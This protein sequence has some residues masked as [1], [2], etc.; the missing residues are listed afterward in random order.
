MWAR[1]LSAGQRLHW[2]AGRESN[3]HSR[4]R[5]VYSQRSSPPAQPTHW[6]A[7]GRDCG[8]VVNP[9]PNM[10]TWSRRR[11]SNP[12]PAV[13]KTAALPIELRRRG[14]GSDR[15]WT[16]RRREMI[17]AKPRTG[18]ASREATSDARGWSGEHVAAP[19]QAGSGPPGRSSSGSGAFD[20]G[21]AGTS[22]LFGVFVGA[23]RR[24]FVGVEASGTAFVAARDRG[25]LDVSAASTGF[26]ATV[27]RAPFAAVRLAG[28]A[29]ADAPPDVTVSS[30]ALAFA[31]PRRGAG[32]AVA[33]ASGASFTPTSCGVS[34]VALGS[35]SPT[36]WPR[37]GVGSLDR[38]R[39]SVDGEASGPLP[40]SSRTGHGSAPT[41]RAGRSPAPSGSR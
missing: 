33:S 6:K 1:N 11:D 38:D 37:A 15:R 8:P 24:G 31:F 10:C 21:S 40:R 35:R 20:S 19:R 32:V 3:P 29:L 23:R 27:V 39:R 22:L 41:G 16:P 9:S 34:A 25:L 7:T 28:F 30:V 14:A 12:E 17:R 36:L 5:L 18:Q 4:R 13:Y 26:V 2:W